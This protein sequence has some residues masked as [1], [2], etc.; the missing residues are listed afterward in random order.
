MPNARIG[1]VVGGI[2]RAAA[3]A[4][5]A[6]LT[7]GQLLTRFITDRDEVAFAELVAR[8]GPTVFAVCRRVL[9]DHHAAEDTFQ[10]VFVVLARKAHT[11]RPREAVAGWVHGVARKAALEAF[12]VRRR[13]H[14][15]ML[16]AVVP[17]APAPPA[18]DPPEPDVLAALEAAIAALSEP[19]R[20]AVVL[21]ELRGVPR[22]EAARQLGI[23]EGTLSSRLAAARKLLAARLRARGVALSAAALTAALAAAG[24]AAVP[25]ELAAAAA[26][27]ALAAS[28][29]GAVSAITQEV[30][31]SMA[32]N[33]LKRV[34]V[35]LL[36][37]A[38][39]VVGLSR[40]AP[41]PEAVT[42]T[43]APVPAELV[44]RIWLWD[45]SKREV[46]TLKL[47]GS[48]P[49][50]VELK[51]GKLVRWV[52]PA[53]NL[54]WFDGKEG[55]LPDT[56]P[57]RG[58]L[59]LHVRPLNDPTAR[60]TDLGIRSVDLV[61]FAQDGRTALAHGGV[62]QE[63]AD[64]PA[65][66][67]RVLVDAVT[68][69]RTPFELPP[70]KGLPGGGY[71]ACDFAPDGLWVLANENTLWRPEQER[72]NEGMPQFRLHKVPLDRGKP[73]LLTGRLNTS[74]GRISPDGKQVLTNAYGDAAKP[75]WQQATLYLIDVAT[76]K[77]TKISG[78][79]NQAWAWGVWS[80]DGRRLACAWGEKFEGG[81]TRLVV[82]DTDGSN[83]RLLLTTD[84][85]VVPITWQ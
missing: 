7:D 9:G 84:E 62:Q 47:D 49:R 8:L 32:A 53:Q 13:R 35:G 18:E 39:L 37:A 61:Y 3:R 67:K 27:A 51:E 78:P 4:E 76:Q 85:H 1:A 50:R 20:A 66:Y 63:G 41:G 19:Y 16:V 10:A 56:V 70:D 28:F 21:C 23:P 55:Q 59:T 58:S 15:E 25:V 45:D 69:K 17:D 14:R 72:Q 6:A 75:A 74:L 81:K 68:K 48:D 80:P 38:G 64:R 11:V 65:D 33:K 77:A 12:A 36:L 40:V 34:T 31:R 71:F 22:K 42:A 43:A 26:R 24:R 29:S 57:A 54:V 52:S 5:A 30:L 60:A 46:T 73:I 44:G 82:C 2:C 79:G 83:A